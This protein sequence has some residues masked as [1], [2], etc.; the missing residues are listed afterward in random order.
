M[1]QHSTGALKAAEQARTE[2]RPTVCVNTLTAGQLSGAFCKMFVTEQIAANWTSG[3][4]IW[5]FCATKQTCDAERRRNRLQSVY[6]LSYDK[7]SYHIPI[8]HS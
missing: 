3:V 5:F 1:L 7:R 6:P 8:Q 2:A 4:V